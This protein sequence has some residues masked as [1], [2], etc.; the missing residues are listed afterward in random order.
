MIQ[1]SQC[2]FVPS[3]VP[4]SVEGL[5]DTILIPASFIRIYVSQYQD[6]II[7]VFQQL[8]G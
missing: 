7:I 4:Y 1:R 6:R 3:N 5:T 8:L 2:L